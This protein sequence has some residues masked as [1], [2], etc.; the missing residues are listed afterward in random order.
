MFNLKKQA[1][2][3]EKTVVKPIEKKLNDYNENLGNSQED[4]PGNIE[5]QQK[6]VQKDDKDIALTPY[7][8]LIKDNRKQQEL[9]TTEARL[10]KLKNRDEVSDS[11]M[12]MGNIAEQKHEMKKQA[13]LEVK[14]VQFWDKYVD[15]YIDTEK[16]VPLNNAKSQLLSNYK[17]RKQ[18]DKEVG[19]KQQK[20]PKINVQVENMEKTAS[21]KDAD[22]MIYFIYRKAAE[23]KREI[24]ATERQIIDDINSSKIRILGE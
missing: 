10:N 14:D 20:T 9:N 19:V 13:K 6:E 24:N 2:K 1:K 3:F 5:Y 12:D 8:N 15:S 22:G 17:T 16:K 23:E 21:L 18:F 11:I 7:Q 4:F